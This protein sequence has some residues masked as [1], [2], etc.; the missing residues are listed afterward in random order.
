MAPKKAALGEAAAATA[1]VAPTTGGGAAAVKAAA[2]TSV[3]DTY[4]KL[5]QHEH[6]LQR[7]DTYVGS[8]EPVT[9][10]MF[11]YDTETSR[12]AMRKITYVPSLYK[13]FDEIV[14]NAADNKQRDSSMTELK[15]DI[16]REKNKLSVYNNGKGIPVVVHKEH[17]I[18]VPELIFGHLLTGSNYNDDKKKV[19][20]G[21]NGYGAKLCNIFSTE[22]VV[23]TADSNEGKKFKQARS[24]PAP[25]PVPSP[26]LAHPRAPLA[27]PP[28][29]P[30]HCMRSVPHTPVRCPPCRRTRTTC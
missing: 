13:I 7:P 21:R 16:D 8:I 11:V 4:K 6:I 5:T 2:G 19:V 29:L 30:P 27:P 23:E 22:F 15:I 9:S 10:D 12:M 25:A 17:N 3:E 24:R 14:V 18:Y 20:G 28:H 1:N 26:P